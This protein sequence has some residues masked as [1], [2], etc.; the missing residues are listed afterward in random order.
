MTDIERVNGYI[1]NSFPCTRTDYQ[2]RAHASTFN[3]EF[4]LFTKN[5]NRFKMASLS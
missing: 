1:D 5:L 4:H 2:G 3:H